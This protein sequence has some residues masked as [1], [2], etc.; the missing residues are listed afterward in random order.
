VNLVEAGKIEIAAIHDVNLSGSNSPPLAAKRMISPRD[1]PLLATGW[2]I[3]KTL[4]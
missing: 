4:T 2:F 1:T 3:L